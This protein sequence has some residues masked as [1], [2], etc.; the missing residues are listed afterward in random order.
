MQPFLGAVLPAVFL[1]KHA[2]N[3]SPLWAEVWEAIERSALRLY[4][5]DIVTLAVKSLAASSWG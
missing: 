1:A 2:P 3:A 5:N 4:G